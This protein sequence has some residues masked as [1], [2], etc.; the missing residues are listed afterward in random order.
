MSSER[1]H[2][3]QQAATAASIDL[4]EEDA[5]ENPYEP[6]LS[7]AQAYIASPK[8]KLSELNVIRDWLQT[9]VLPVK[10]PIEARRGYWT[11]TKNKVRNAKRVGTANR[12][13]ASGVSLDPDFVHRNSGSG[14]SSTQQ[15][16]MEDSSYEKASWRFLFECAR[17]GRLDLCFEMCK[18][19]N[20]SWKAA[21]LRGGLL[22]GNP[23]LALDEEDDT[24]EGASSAAVGNRKR[25]LWKAVCRK[26]ASE[27]TA[28]SY[29]CALYGSLG[30]ELAPV[31]QVSH[32]WEEHL[33]AFIN[34]SFEAKL[35]QLLDSGGSD[36][37]NWWCGKQDEAG[38]TGS[39]AEDG[40]L[41]G[42]ASLTL[43]DIFE[44]LEQ[45]NTDNIQ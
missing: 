36:G 1:H 23:L 35:D 44:R 13:G 43:K 3:R 33:W 37:K 27:H 12:A 17:N 5:S 7:R 9:H 39:Q 4:A 24:Q 26:L 38:E 2:L 45:T 28:D 8:Y 10:H 14:T 20:Q 34:A 21:S 32:S 25:A 15:L 40:K 30:G 41:R 11:F 18:E 6:P 29:E 19:M 31:L 42:L 22:Y 16:E